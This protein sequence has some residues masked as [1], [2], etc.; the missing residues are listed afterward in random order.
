MV[1][2]GSDELAKLLSETGLTLYEVGIEP[3]DDGRVY[4]IKII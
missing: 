1:E 4:E 2:W 3:V